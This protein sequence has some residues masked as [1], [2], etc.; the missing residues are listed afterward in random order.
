[1]DEEEEEAEKLEAFE[2][3]DVVEADKERGMF[4]C[5]DVAIFL[6]PVGEDEEDRPVLAVISVVP[7][8][9]D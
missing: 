1:M 9:A 4:C 3:V 5:T 8:A 6:R 2:L 7:V